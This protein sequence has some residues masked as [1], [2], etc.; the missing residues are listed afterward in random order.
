M[1]FTGSL[2]DAAEAQRI[3]LVEQLAEDPMLAAGELARSMQ[4]A[5]GFSQA[6][7]KGIIRRILEGATDDDEASAALFD[8]AFTGADFREGVAAFLERRPA[9]FPS[10]NAPA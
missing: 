6:G 2:L 10:R 8:S 1:L 3:G 5:S 7:I 4:A 9:R